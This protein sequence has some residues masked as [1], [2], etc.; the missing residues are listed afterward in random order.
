MGV[1]TSQMEGIEEDVPCTQNNPS[2][3]SD[4]PGDTSGSAELGEHPGSNINSAEHVMVLQHSM[5]MPKAARQVQ[6]LKSFRQRHFNPHQV[7]L[8]RRRDKFV[9]IGTPRPSS[10][11]GVHYEDEK[12]H[13]SCPSSMISVQTTRTPNGVPT[14]PTSDPTVRLSSQ[15]SSS[16]HH[17]RS[18]ITIGNSIRTVEEV[19]EAYDAVMAGSKN[20]ESLPAPWHE[21]QMKISQ[22]LTRK[23]VKV[24]APLACPK[25]RSS[26]TND[27]IAISNDIEYLEQ[28][29]NIRTWNMHKMI[30]SA[31]QHDAHPPLT[32]PNRYDI[33]S[34][35]HHVDLESASMIF[36]ME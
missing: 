11:H 8:T 19:K 32:I 16:H 9:G 21:T 34:V 14:R 2:S 4:S 36:D 33:N 27:S 10:G 12:Y 5:D 30:S 25:Q 7:L 6:D 18:L 29:Y 3:V 1:A 35:D 22:Y 13:Y 24:T 15:G 17:P 28:L 23:E 31:R 20:D 26:Q